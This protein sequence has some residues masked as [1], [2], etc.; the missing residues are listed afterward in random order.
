MLRGFIASL[1]LLGALPSL[2]LAQSYQHSSDGLVTV[3][4][5]Q[6]VAADQSVGFEVCAQLL[7]QEQVGPLEVRLNFWGTSGGMLA[8]ASSL[9]HPETAAPVCRR[10]L[11]PARARNFG[12][13][14]IS[15]FRFQPN[16][17]PQVAGRPGQK[18]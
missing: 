8:H 2:A 7:R 5:K 14:E 6:V 16:P 9:L 11:L 13:W 10:V 17:M 12:R 4:V 15:R 1:A 3:H 18:G